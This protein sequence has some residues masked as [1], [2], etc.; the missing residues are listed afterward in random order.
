MVKAIKSDTTHKP[1]LLLPQTLADKA[2]IYR[3]KMTRSE[4]LNFCMD[5][6]AI[7][8]ADDEYTKRT[9]NTRL[10]QLRA[11]VIMHNAVLEQAIDEGK[12]YVTEQDF[13]EFKQHIEEMHKSLIDFV[14]TSVLNFVGNGSGSEE[15][16]P[17]QEM[18]RL[19]EVLEV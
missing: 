8:I 16:T 14:V 18:K 9:G 17:E 12:A 15:D 2:D 5:W 19:L 3:G 10:A 13:T 4:F 7:N 11:D 1:T 6:M